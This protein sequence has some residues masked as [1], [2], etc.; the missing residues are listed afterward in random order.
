MIRTLVNRSIL[1]TDL[2]ELDGS[3]S[4]LDRV[5]K[6]IHQDS[7]RTSDKVDSLESDLTIIKNLLSKLLQT[8]S[9]VIMEYQ[10]SISVPLEDMVYQRVYEFVESKERKVLVEEILPYLLETS[11][12]AKRFLAKEDQN[13]PAGGK[14]A[15]SFILED[16][17]KQLYEKTNNPAYNGEFD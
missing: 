4:K 6:S 8:Q 2:E 15:L 7:Q 1:E 5:V 14:I 3:S 11:I 12:E 16:V 17:L 13:L 9:R 10:T